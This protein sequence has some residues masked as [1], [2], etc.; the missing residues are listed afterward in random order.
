MRCTIESGRATWVFDL[1][2]AVTSELSFRQTD[3]TSC[4]SASGMFLF[5]KMAGSGDAHVQITSGLDLRMRVTAGSPIS[6][7]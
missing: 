7:A 6:N 4:V 1:S 5:H 2:S 3:T